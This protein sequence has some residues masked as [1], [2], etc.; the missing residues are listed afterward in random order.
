MFPGITFIAMYDA[1]GNQLIQN[2]SQ[3]KDVI[4]TQIIIKLLQYIIYYFLTCA[5]IALEFD[6][7]F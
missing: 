2:Q 4:G 6:L 1:I 3:I 5:D 7:K